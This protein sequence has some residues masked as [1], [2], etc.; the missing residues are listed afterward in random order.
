L[1]LQHRG[2]FQLK[3]ARTGRFVKD[4]I[5]AKMY[6]RSNERRMR[7]ADL[8]VEYEGQSRL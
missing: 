8:D 2:I 1:R 5:E 4:K 6:A 7:G 3:I